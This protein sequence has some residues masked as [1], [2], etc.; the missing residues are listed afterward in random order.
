M[1]INEYLKKV[2]ISYLKS[3]RS[4]TTIRTKLHYARAYAEGESGLDALRSK[5]IEAM[6]SEKHSIGEQIAILY[7]KETCPDEYEAYQAF[8]AECKSK[9]DAIMADLRVELEAALLAE[10]NEPKE[11]PSIT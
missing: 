11:M 4:D 2:R 3:G 1:T 5:Q 10:K 8:R 9:V 6:I 7:N